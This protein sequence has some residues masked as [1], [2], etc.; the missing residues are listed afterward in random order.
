MKEFARIDPVQTLSR[1]VQTLSFKRNTGVRL[2]AAP[3]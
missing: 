3:F 2:T 1:P